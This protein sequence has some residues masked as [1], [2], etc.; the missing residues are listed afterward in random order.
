MIVAFVMQSLIGVAQRGNS[1][2]DKYFNQNQF[3]QALKYY[4]QDS[5]ARKRKV[6]EYA[7]LKVADC[8]RIMG[9]FDKAEIA[10]KKIQKRKKKDPMSY[11]NYG[12]SLKS[13]SKYAEAKVQF[14]EY[15]TLNPTDLRGPIFLASCDSAQEWLDATIG[16]EVKN[17]EKINTQNSEFSPFIYSNE[18][19]FA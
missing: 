1:K 11:L 17:I 10:Y 8:Y 15:I 12:L 3:D 19:Y 7:Q 2:G 6:S 13:S 9:E 4:M 5:K 14:Q 18:L 16:R